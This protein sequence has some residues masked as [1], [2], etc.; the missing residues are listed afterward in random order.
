MRLLL[1]LLLALSCTIG[2]ANAI[3]QPGTGELPLTVLADA[4]FG[5]HLPADRWTSVRVIVSPRQDSIEGI[6]RV[7]FTGPGGMDLRS[8]APLTT[9]PGR[10]T[11]LPMTVWIPSRFDTMQV[12]F[13]DLRAPTGWHTVRPERVI[14]EHPYPGTFDQSDRAV[15]WHS[16]PSPGIRIRCIFADP[17]G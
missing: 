9:T 6:V 2:T 16:G 14:D 8:I 17:A 15:G 10:E 13:L 12:E 5:G 11:V 4:G 1:V 7:R 3:A